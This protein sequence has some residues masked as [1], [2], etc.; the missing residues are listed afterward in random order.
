MRFVILIAFVLYQ[1]VLADNLEQLWI[2]YNLIEKLRNVESMK[3]LQVFYVG[4]NNIEDMNEVNRMA[5]LPNLRDL[6]LTG[7]PLAENTDP[8][9]Y[10]HD[11]CKRLKQLIVLDGVPIVRV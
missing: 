9:V 4:N 6:L 10:R 5:Q 8:D 7:N 2:S 11:V 1:E 3:K